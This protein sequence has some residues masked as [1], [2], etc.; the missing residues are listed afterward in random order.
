MILEKLK[1]IPALRAIA[2]LAALLMC[3]PSFAYE[4]PKDPPSGVAMAVDLLVARPL[5]LG[6]TV[7]S[8][9]IFI[10]GLPFNAAGG[11]V[12]DSAQKLVVAPVMATF[13]RCLGC[14]DSGYKRQ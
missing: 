5:L 13:V 2:L 7:V 12:K 6:M 3:Q 1:N 11:N 10:V 14:I 8:T 4:P 9:A